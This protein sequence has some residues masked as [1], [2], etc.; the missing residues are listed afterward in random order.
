MTEND[1]IINEDIKKPLIEIDND[2]IEMSKNLKIINSLKDD[3]DEILDSISIPD[4]LRNERR[5]DKRNLHF[6]NV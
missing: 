4:T 1:I 3:I 5:K 2:L 6:E